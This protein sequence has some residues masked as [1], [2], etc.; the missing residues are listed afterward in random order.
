MFACRE[1][2]DVYN[3]CKNNFYDIKKNEKGILSSFLRLCNISVV[4]F[5]CLTYKLYSVFFK[6]TLLFFS[7]QLVISDTVHLRVR[8]IQRTEHHIF[9]D[10]YLKVMVV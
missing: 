3:L 8:K 9:I 4:K 7:R 2:I 5:Q 10:R 1:F 6:S